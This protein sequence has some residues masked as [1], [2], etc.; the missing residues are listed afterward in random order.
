LAPAV[1]T[2]F[3][4]ALVIGV[5]LLFGA[6]ETGGKLATNYGKLSDATVPKRVEGVVVESAVRVERNSIVIGTEV[7]KA[8][9]SNACSCTVD[10]T[11]R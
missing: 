9:I 4:T 5:N 6:E 11:T 10:D 3:R 1:T 7:S 8:T 2:A